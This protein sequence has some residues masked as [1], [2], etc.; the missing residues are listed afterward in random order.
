MAL[1][2]STSETCH[3]QTHQ[4]ERRLPDRWSGVRRTGRLKWS[5]HSMPAKPD[6]ER[7]WEEKSRNTESFQ[8]ER[9]MREEG[10]HTS[11]GE[12]RIVRP[13]TASAVLEIADCYSLS[14]FVEMAQTTRGWE[15]MLGG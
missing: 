15:D 3:R 12:A 11:S 1:S 13:K 2:L 6:H 5:T 14:D 4:L 9:M 8:I 7:Y 10:V